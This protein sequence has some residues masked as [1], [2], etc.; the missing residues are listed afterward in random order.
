M[1]EF[2]NDLIGQQI[3]LGGGEPLLFRQPEFGLHVENFLPIVLCGGMPCDY[4]L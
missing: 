2:L 3:G 4:S 1:E